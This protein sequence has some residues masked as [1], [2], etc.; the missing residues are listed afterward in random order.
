[1][2]RVALDPRLRRFA[3][4]W[5]A[6][7]VIFAIGVVNVS[8]HADSAAYPGAPWR[9]LVFL[10]VAVAALGVRRRASLVAPCFAIAT[11][12]WWTALWPAGLQGPFEG[13]VVLV[14]AAYSLGSLNSGRRLAVGAALLVAWFLAGLVVGIVGSGGLG[15]V[16][17]ILVWCAVGFGIGYLISRR[18]EQVRLARQATTILAAE[19][20][21]QTARAVEDE[22]ARIARELHDVVAHGLS[23]IV[24]QAVAERRSLHGEDPDVQSIDSALESIE[25]AGREALVDL[26]RLLGLLRRTDEPATLAPQPGLEQLDDL[27]APVRA[28]GVAVAVEIR[29]RSTPLPPGLDLTAYRIIQEAVT[30]VLKH[31]QA[32][33]VRVVIAYERNQLELE[34]SDDGSA[35]GSSVVQGQST[36]GGGG[37]GLIGMRERAT[38]F[39]GTISAGRTPG[40]GWTVHARLPIAAVVT[41]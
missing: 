23:V 35:V 7:V 22:R 39:G 36:L 5:L 40:S 4:D 10:G 28:A 34:V 3:L 41:G 2:E 15:D 38:V 26:R 9:H 11:V 31:A 16:V 21:R 32:T 13:F 24:V 25:H 33:T 17:P 18:T 8:Q 29:G 12:T 27:L 1:M 20:E 6:P 14:G 19:Q 30:N 37:H